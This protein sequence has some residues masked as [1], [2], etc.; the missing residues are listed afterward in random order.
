MAMWERAALGVI[1]VGAFVARVVLCGKLEM[2]VDEPASVLAARQVAELGL[3]RFPSGVLYTQGFLQ[4]YLLAP[5]HLLGRATLDQLG[6]MRLISAI[7]GTAAIPVTW[8]L[9]RMA[10]GPVCGLLAAF[11][12]ACD[13]ASLE[14]SA[15]VRPYALLQLVAVG[16]AWMWCRAISAQG[17]RNDLLAAGA[18]LAVGTFTHVGIL[19]LV[20]GM[21][22]AAAGLWGTELLRSRRDLSIGLASMLV[23]PAAFFGLNRLAGTTSAG[24]TDA[25]GGKV[26]FVG[27]HLIDL[28]ALFEPK[29]TAWR[30]LYD[31]P[32]L[33]DTVLGTVLVTA[34]SALVAWASAPPDATAERAARTGVLAI[35]SLAIGGM[36]FLVADPQGR[37]LLHLQPLI[38]VV[39]A[40]V[41]AD[42]L[43]G[44][45]R[46]R[47]PRKLL[48]GVVGLLWV[49]LHV[50]L[51]EGRLR[52]WRIDSVDYLPPTRHVATMVKPDEALAFGITPVALI[53]LGDRPNTW[54]LAGPAGSPRAT[55]YTR[56]TP[57]GPVDYW[58]GWPSITSV[59]ALC[60]FVEDNPRAWMVVDVHRMQDTTGWAGAFT[61]VLEGSTRVVWS[62]RDGARVLRPRP[63]ADWTK[64]A[65]RLCPLDPSSER[66]P[67]APEPPAVP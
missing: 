38:F 55:R 34:G 8:A 19:L 51:A 45:P 17:T 48:G 40:M 5:F 20:P 9:G 42:L 49:G 47:L 14:W 32:V 57:E 62:T 29:V 37:Y 33:G 59:G 30:M 2:H 67:V 66:G 56:P 54:F 64:D 58:A 35:A 21:A 15:H 4:S 12:L 27:D 61:L 25:M 31:Q 46:D 6:E 1:V 28:S 52:V 65:R 23:A 60:A 11:A 22:L 43:T 3:P 53:E 50:A 36:A 13:A 7:A 16:L 41:V 63:R 39:P 10:G 26:G 18:L 24:A 44:P